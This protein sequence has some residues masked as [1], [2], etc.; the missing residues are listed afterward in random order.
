[1]EGSAWGQE[2]GCR[3]FVV[4]EARRLDQR[5]IAMLING[6]HVHTR[7]CTWQIAC[8]VPEITN[9]IVFG[10]RLP[11]TGASKGQ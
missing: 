8:Y 4:S 10:S 11:S 9:Q 6:V 2:Q 3:Y 5:C 1:M 7:S